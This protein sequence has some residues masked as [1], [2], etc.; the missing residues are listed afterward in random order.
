MLPISPIKFVEFRH[1]ASKSYDGSYTK[2]ILWRDI[3]TFSVTLSAVRIVAI[4]IAPVFVSVSCGNGH[5]TWTSR[6]N[7][8]R[9]SSGTGMTAASFWSSYRNAYALTRT[10]PGTSQVGRERHALSEALETHPRGK[11]IFA[12]EPDVSN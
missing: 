5:S 1:G 12:P 9:I 4:F 10:A 3:M 7:T 11:R 2:N 8:Y 6:Q